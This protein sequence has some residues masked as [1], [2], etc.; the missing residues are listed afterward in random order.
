MIHY[1]I[2]IF[3]FRIKITSKYRKNRKIKFENFNKTMKFYAHRNEIAKDQAGV[4]NNFFFSYS[5][6]ISLLVLI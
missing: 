1:K 6:K 3:D 5:S 2:K 4:I